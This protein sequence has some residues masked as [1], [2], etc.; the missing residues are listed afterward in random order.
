MTMVTNDVDNTTTKTKTAAI[1]T[2]T[3]TTTLVRLQSSSLLSFLP[4]G[5]LVSRVFTAK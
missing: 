2:T 3:T 4:C 1:T 5:C